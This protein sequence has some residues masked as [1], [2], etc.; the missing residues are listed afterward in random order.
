MR[1][2]QTPSLRGLLFVTA[3]TAFSAVTTDAL[4]RENVS[5]GET[6]V[7]V[8]LF[9]SQGC[10]SCPPA[11]RFLQELSRRD[12]VLALSLHVDY[13][14]YIGWRDTF[15]SPQSTDRQRSYA[16]SMGQRSVYTPQMVIDGKFQEVGSR[17]SQVTKFLEY[18]AKNPEHGRAKVS[19]TLTPS[20]GM[21]AEIVPDEKKQKVTKNATVWLM[22]FDRRHETKI[23]SGENAGRTLAY[24]N[25]VRS[26]RPIGDWKGEAKTITINA[27][28]LNASGERDGCAV[29]LQTGRAGP[30]LGA[31]WVK[32]RD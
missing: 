3:W 1:I 4:S 28:E 25:V 6:P 23:R 16:R 30:V 15:A 26:I 10:S 8:E 9:T 7:V 22:E 2:F 20:G 31:A 13:W 11:D 29:I 27:A 12:D 17:R 24:V 19:L 5:S 18:H 32:L 14:D 21:T